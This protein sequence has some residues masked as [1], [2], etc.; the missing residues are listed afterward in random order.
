M[1]GV[2]GQRSESAL[3]GPDIQNYVRAILNI[4]ADFTDEKAGMVNNQRAV[5]NI[6]EDSAGDKAQQDAAQR[7]ILNILED[8]AAE[9]DRAKDIQRAVLN[10]LDDV[11]VERAKIEEANILLR[12]EVAARAVAE[13]SLLR[14]KS[15][16]EASNREL[17]AFSYS[18]AHDLRAPLRSIDGFSA[19]L[20]EDCADQVDEQGKNYIGLVRA[21]AQQMAKLIDDLLALS[22]V[23]RAELQRESV[24]LAE[25]AHTVAATLRNAQPRR[26]ADIV[27]PGELMVSADPR[28]MRIVMENL[29]GNAWKFTSKRDRARI[30]FSRQTDGNRAIYFVR[31]NGAGFDM[32][33]AGKLFGAFQRLHSP[34]EFDGTGIGLAI[35]KRIVNRHGGRVWAEGEVGVGATVY[36]TLEEGT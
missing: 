19:A 7:A 13:E 1:A 9:T 31:D 12:K 15:A 27:M 22:R 10:V 30:E 20:L 8:A 25:I 16:A 33:Y 24:N 34:A 14:A 23:N 4:L 21:S 5:L 17:E 35:V 3:S 6:L 36:F 11:D 28:L 26:S 2:D 32:Q 29:L 18:V